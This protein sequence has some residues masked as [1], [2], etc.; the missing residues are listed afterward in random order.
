MN[1]WFIVRDVYPRCTFLRRD[2]RKDYFGTFVNFG[3]RP[4]RVATPC[5]P[6][7]L[8]SR[9]KRIHVTAAAVNWVDGCEETRSER[10]V[11][12]MKEDT[13]GLP[14]DEWIRFHSQWFAFHLICMSINWPQLPENLWRECFCHQSLLGHTLFCLVHSS[15]IADEKLLAFMIPFDDLHTICSTRWEASEKLHLFLSGTEMFLKQ[16]VKIYIAGTC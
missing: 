13:W 1:I 16:F 12:W 6:R 14:S 5:V 8:F 15:S 9:R 2:S 3:S 4:W 7:V 10:K 11:R